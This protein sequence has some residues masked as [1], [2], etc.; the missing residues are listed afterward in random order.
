MLG[1]QT[2]RAELSALPT[3]KGQSQRCA[4]ALLN[5]TTMIWG[6]STSLIDGIRSVTLP[7]QIVILD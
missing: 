6:S 5:G 1:T 7:P 3:L 4:A 2:R